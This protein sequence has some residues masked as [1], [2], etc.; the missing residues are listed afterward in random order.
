MSTILSA[1]YKPTEPTLIAFV[2]L[3]TI[4]IGFVIVCFELIVFLHQ[5][6][7]HKMNK[8]SK[9]KSLPDDSKKYYLATERLALV[10]LFSVILLQTIL[11][12]YSFFDYNNEDNK[13]YIFALIYAIALS[14]ATSSIL[15]FYTFR[16]YLTFKETVFAIS[17][18]TLKSL[19][20]VAISS[21]IVT[22]IGMFIRLVSLFNYPLIG[23]IL[24]TVSW[25][26]CIFEYILLAI[27]FSKKLIALVTMQKTDKKANIDGLKQRYY[28]GGHTNPN[29]RSKHRNNHGNLSGTF[30]ENNNIDYDLDND[31]EPT[32]TGTAAS[33]VVAPGVNI[34]TTDETNSK[35][36]TKNNAE[37]IENIENTENTDNIGN[38]GKTATAL[39]T[40]SMDRDTKTGYGSRFSKLRS[41]SIQTTTR[42]D[43]DGNDNDTVGPLPTLNP[44]LATGASASETIVFS[45]PVGMNR[46]SNI[47]NYTSTIHN[48]INNNN[49]N[50]NRTFNLLNKNKTRN[51][52]YST[53][54]NVTR[55]IQGSKSSSRR[56]SKQNSLEFSNDHDSDNNNNRRH[57]IGGTVSRQRDRER[58]REYSVSGASELSV[59]HFHMMHNVRRSMLSE[60]QKKLIRNITKQTTLIISASMAGLTLTI[61]STILGI[62][63][64]NLYVI[65]GYNVI[66]AL[67]A[68]LFQTGLWLSFIF[69]QKQYKQCCGLFHRFNDFMCVR[70]VIKREG[71]DID[72][73]I[74]E[75]FEA[76]RIDEMHSS[77]CSIDLG[78]TNIKYSGKNSKRTS[79]S[80]TN[81]M[82]SLNVVEQ[83][84]SE[85]SASK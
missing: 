49:K 55:S 71:I 79:V 9:W 74:E 21:G 51:H 81:K 40:S 80:T 44:Q 35:P 57:T 42:G 50:N 62:F 14:S 83:G 6:K 13:N 11:W 56:H 33:A 41:V 63:P 34:N 84:K 23:W 82:M 67:V 20:G 37:N 24:F 46:D 47:I 53:S 4:G 39:A 8:A 45:T 72:E 52:A 27:L 15:I 1:K 78:S 61:G 3:V 28:H 31:N 64:E 43:G 69:A 26:V 25:T 5:S 10:A 85:I 32:L 12:L 16:L 19:L 77:N 65:I 18:K 60:R 22:L 70:L 54:G 58:E 66:R 48:S 75:A 30:D 73:A 38:I 2:E 29:Y 68:V 36:Q 17:K 59:S 76:S 7:K